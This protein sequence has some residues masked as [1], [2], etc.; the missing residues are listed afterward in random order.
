[1]P[2]RTTSCIQIGVLAHA[3][4]CGVGGALHREFV[5][6]A[7]AAGCTE[8]VLECWASNSRAHRF[9][10]RNGWRPDGAR[11]PGPQD[12]D[13]VQLRLKLVPHSS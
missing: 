12:H 13:Y 7:A 11:R 4:G 8:G 1:M 5:A 3:W 6:L 9:Y 10:A 2:Q